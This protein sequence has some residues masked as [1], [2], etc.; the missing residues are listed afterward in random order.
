MDEGKKGLRIDR[1]T[2]IKWVLAAAALMPLVKHGAFAQGKT[3]DA[4]IAARG[5]GTDPDLLKAY[6][7]GDV[8]PL[9]FTPAQRET[10]AVLCDAIIPADD[11]SPAAS[12]VGVVDFIDEWISAPYPQQQA[13]R[14]F[15]LRG[16]EWLDEETRRRFGRTFAAASE[17]QRTAICDDICDASTAKP[18]L[19]DAARFFAVYRDLVAG[20]FYTTPVGMKDL[21]YVGN[22][23]LARFDGPPAEVL[24][25][26]GLEPSSG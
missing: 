14:T 19:A 2:T 25:K 1:R 11:V 5:Y 12:S 21:Q 16:L 4:A 6:K 3:A 17:T 22:V 7:P 23:P 18:G 20:G 10:A 26:V 13:D 9:T 24:R 15:V 8:W